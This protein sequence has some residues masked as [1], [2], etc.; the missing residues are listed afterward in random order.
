MKLK[1]VTKTELEYLVWIAEYQFDA[2]I[3]NCLFSSF[4]S[5][6]LIY[7]GSTRRIRY[8]Y[9]II[10]NEYKLYLI[11]RAQD[12]LFSLTPSSGKVIKECTKA[13]KYRVMI[14]SKVTEFIKR[15]GNVF[16]K[17]VKMVDK[18][19][20]AGDEAIITDENDNLLAV[21]RMKLSG[22]EILAYKRG[23]AVIV[24]RG[25][26]DEHQDSIEK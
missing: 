25:V 26:G 19:L 21:G 4:S 8:I 22:E 7:S 24:R 5:Y 13:P 3:A 11:L 1:E 12:N 20:R 16:C 23:V 2:D 17:H 10:N 9:V 6:F 15:G 14:D 18:N